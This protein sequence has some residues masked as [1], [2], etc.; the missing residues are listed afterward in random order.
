VPASVWPIAL[1]SAGAHLEKLVFE[2]RVRQAHDARYIA[3][4]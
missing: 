4:E 2:G 1:L 3:N